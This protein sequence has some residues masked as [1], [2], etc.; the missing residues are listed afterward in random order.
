MRPSAGD[1]FRRYAAEVRMTLEQLRK[2][3]TEDPLIDKLIDQCVLEPAQHG[4]FCVVDGRVL[5][6]LA[7]REGIPSFKVLLT[8]PPGVAAFRLAIKDGIRPSEA[9]KRIE[10]RDREDAERLG[11]LYDWRPDDRSYYDLVIATETF[12]P[13]II[14]ARIIAAAERAPVA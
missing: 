6:W 12:T 11:R 14:A 10:A 2:R 7:H 5:A 1:L 4:Q 3:A 9:R 8:V 13:A